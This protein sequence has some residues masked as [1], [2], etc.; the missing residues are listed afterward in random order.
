M[1]VCIYIYI[2]NVHIHIYKYIYI[3]AGQDEIGILSFSYPLIIH[4]KLYI[5]YMYIIHYINIMCIWVSLTK[6]NQ[7]L[8]SQCSA[9]I[10][11]LL[12]WTILET[13]RLHFI[14]TYILYE[15]N[16]VFIRSWWIWW[17]S[18]LLPVKMTMQKSF[19][20]TIISITI[21]YTMYHLFQD[22]EQWFH[23]QHIEHIFVNLL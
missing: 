10:C 21:I 8:E 22:H 15:Y 4:Y 19:H 6:T 12:N 17:T 20:L 18:H 7:M 3:V 11:F 14:Y 16:G 13:N 9:F 1:H 2:Y 23:W 5:L